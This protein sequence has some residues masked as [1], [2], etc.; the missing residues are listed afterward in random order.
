MSSRRVSST[1]CQLWSTARTS[2]LLSRQGTADLDSGAEGD[3][4]GDVAAPVEPQDKS[5]DEPVMMK[6]S[7]RLGPFQMQILECKTTPLFGETAHV[8]VAPL[9]AGEVQLVG[10]CPL[11]LGL[12]VLHAYTRLKM[13]SN[14]VSSLCITC[15]TVPSF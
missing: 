10:S 7:L 9:K 2:T 6:E 13:G 1:G 15:Q 11:S 8:M 4:E 12:H 14:K 5:I 3:A